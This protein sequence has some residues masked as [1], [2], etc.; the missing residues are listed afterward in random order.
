M[1][2]YLDPQCYLYKLCCDGFDFVT[3]TQ[4]KFSS[5]EI[6]YANNHTIIKEFEKLPEFY[7]YVITQSSKLESLYPTHLVSKYEMGYFKVELGLN[8]HPNYILFSDANI[9]IWE[10]II[11][12]IGLE[13]LVAFSRGTDGNINGFGMR[14]LNNDKLLPAFKWLFPMGQHC[15]FGLHDV[16][17][18][19]N[20]IV[21]VE[22]F[23]DYIAFRES[24]HN[25]VIGLGSAILEPGHQTIL[26]DFK[27]IQC[28][29]QDAFGSSLRRTF[30][31]QNTPYCYY[32][33][34]AK[35]PY[36]SYLETGR[37]DIVHVQ[38]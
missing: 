8:F 38:K 23:T 22:G 29:D 6:L 7:N 16:I 32:I 13:F 25:N 33:P 26:R 9:K 30:D 27:I 3:N 34:N 10:E 28:P 31:V 2:N 12:I 37:V 35:D 21:T 20:T 15:T 4:F 18:I 1:K 19:N 36:E 14:L 17:P 24:G 11:S 5:E